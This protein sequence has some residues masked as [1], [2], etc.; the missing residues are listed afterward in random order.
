MPRRHSGQ[1]RHCVHIDR[2][3]FGQLITR[4]CRMVWPGAIAFRSVTLPDPHHTG[5]GQKARLSRRERNFRVH[6]I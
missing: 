3:P 1:Q 2:N 4:R 6:E 5:A